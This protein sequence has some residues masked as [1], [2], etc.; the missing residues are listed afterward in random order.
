MNIEEYNILIRNQNFLKIKN[1]IKSG[2]LD[3]NKINDENFRYILSD[4]S[5]LENHNYNSDIKDS[6]DFLFLSKKYNEIISIFENVKSNKVFINLYIAKSYYQL[7]EIQKFSTYK[8][9][10]FKFIKENKLWNLCDLYFNSL[11]EILD[12]DEVVIS[13]TEYL[14]ETCQYD[15]LENYIKEL[16]D[17]SN[18]QYLLRKTFKK[19]KF[20]CEEICERLELYNKIGQSIL[21]NDEK[22]K[23]LILFYDKKFEFKKSENKLK[24][25]ITKK[26]EEVSESSL[27]LNCIKNEKEE[28]QKIAYV[29][30]DEEIF[31]IER[32]RKD[33]PYFKSINRDLVVSFLNMEMYELVVK[34]IEKFEVNPG[35]VY[36]KCEALLNM[37]KY[38]HVIDE[39]NLNISNESIAFRY[40]KALAYRS[41]GLKD[42]AKKELKSIA[43]DDSR[44]RRTRELLDES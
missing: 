28:V 21:T 34:Y 30:S 18:N 41:M 33:D 43:L 24:I 17:R 8:N 26:Q 9:D 32:L 40:L 44:F 4:F 12:E 35:L 16:I 27:E 3:L 39:I 7:G 11:K 37:G 42:S 1:F 5:A 31:L 2:V 14:L 15:E 29:K 23:S 6:L 38:S 20:A 25:T 22:V 13:K 19:I 10:I 36:L